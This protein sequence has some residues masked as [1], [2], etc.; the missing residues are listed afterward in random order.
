M[1]SEYKLIKPQ[2]MRQYP[3]YECIYAMKRWWEIVANHSY[4]L[5]VSTADDDGP[6]DNDAGDNVGYALD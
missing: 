1:D 4:S 6:D 3:S 5:Y 2:H